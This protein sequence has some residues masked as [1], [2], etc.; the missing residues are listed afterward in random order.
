MPQP[1]RKSP[2][3]DNLTVD[4]SGRVL[5][6]SQPAFCAHLSA[7]FVGAGILPFNATSLNRGNHFDTSS[8]KFTAP[9]AGVYFFHYHNNHDAGT[10]GTGS[11]LYADFYKNGLF[12]GTNR[13]YTYFNGGWEELSGSITI[14]LQAGDYIQVRLQTGHRADS[15]SYSCFA[16]YLIG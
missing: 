2:H 9:V 8:Y 16:G 1:L 6:P 13:M 15:G 4:T 12:T 5:M 3:G 14:A 10:A 7:G 11:A